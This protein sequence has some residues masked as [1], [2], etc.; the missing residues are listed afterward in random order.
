M[1]QERAMYSHQWLSRNSQL[2]IPSLTII[3]CVWPKHNPS[4]TWPMNDCTPDQ[5]PATWST[6]SEPKRDGKTHSV[7]SCLIQTE[8]PILFIFVGD[9]EEAKQ[10]WSLLKP[11][12][13]Q[14]NV[15][16]GHCTFF[17]LNAFN[18]PI[19]KNFCA[20]IHI[21][22]KLAKRIPRKLARDWYQYVNERHAKSYFDQNF[23]RV[24][25]PCHPHLT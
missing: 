12:A 10:A 14:E 19:A 18:C 23:L 5:T 8:P 16:V 1:I 7:L 20:H 24:R 4:T 22:R 13:F 25:H 9:L 17:P 6:M 21:G 3:Q 2:M 15:G 11:A